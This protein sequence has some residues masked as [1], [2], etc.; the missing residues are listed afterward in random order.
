MLRTIAKVAGGAVVAE[1]IQFFTQFEG[2]EDGFRARARRAEELLHSERT[3][4]TLVCAPRRDTVEEALYLVSQ[5]SGTGARVST[6]VVNRCYPRFAPISAASASALAGTSLAPLAV[7]LGQL[8]MLVAKED[9]QLARVSEALPDA[10][11]IRVPFLAR[12]V[13]DLEALA[14]VSSYLGP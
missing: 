7:N 4:F 1:T 14:E 12:D 6:V 2:M 3:S 8:G 5:M 13:S 9:E 10:T 11:V